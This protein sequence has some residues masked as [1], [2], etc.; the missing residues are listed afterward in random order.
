MPKP[1][2]KKRVLQLRDISLADDGDPPSG[3]LRGF[4]QSQLVSGFEP[5]HP[6]VKLAT[7]GRS[8][9]VMTGGDMWALLCGVGAGAG[10]WCSS[11]SGMNGFTSVGEECPLR[12]RASTTP[13][14]PS[15]GGNTS[16]V[17]WHRGCR[18]RRTRR[19]I[20][21]QKTSRLG[22]RERARGASCHA[23]GNFTKV[24]FPH[25]LQGVFRKDFPSWTENQFIFL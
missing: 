19:K 4:R 5:L 3:W 20:H 17:S 10:S 9:P 12:G 23:E 18:L 7:Q 15:P 25:F 24:R 2:Q 14:H 22:W 11:W 21:R 6:N 13:W 16:Q 1:G 8:Q